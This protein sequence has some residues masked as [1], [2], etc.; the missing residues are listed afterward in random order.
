M[1]AEL[2]RIPLLVAALMPAAA[3]TAAGPNPQLHVTV[4]A[5]PAAVGDRVPVRVEAMDGAG[6]LWGDVQAEVGDR[7]DWAVAG[8][9]KTVPDATVPT[10]VVEL[11]PLR[12]G[13]LPLPRLHAALRSADGSRRDVSAA[14]EPTVTVASVLPPGKKIKPAPLTA[15]I[16]ARGFPWE[17]VV[18]GVL[19]LLPVILLLLWFLRRRRRRRSDSAGAPVLL[20]LDELMALVGELRGRIGHVPAEL[21]C[22]RLAAAVR[23][24]LARR[25]GE[26]VQEMTSFEVRRLARRSAWPSGVQA[27]LGEAMTLADGVRFARRPAGDDELGRGLDRTVEAAR[28][29]DAHLSA[30]ELADAEQVA[31]EASA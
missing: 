7:G 3:G 9:P 12:V 29:L 16:G 30:C 15:P 4:P 6:G 21:I 22:D 17:W 23:R 24:F 2:L 27:A 31:R 26:P 5:G 10:W 28:E 14:A 1:R 13:K 25:S 8:A 11:V 19:L 18:P 20:P